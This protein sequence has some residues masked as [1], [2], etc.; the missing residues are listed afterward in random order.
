MELAEKG[1]AGSWVR[2]FNRIDQSTLLGVMA[3][4]KFAER[5]L[6]QHAFASSG[7]FDANA[8]TT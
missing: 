8:Q 4:F 1:L 3:A 6:G 7:F 5:T 2:V